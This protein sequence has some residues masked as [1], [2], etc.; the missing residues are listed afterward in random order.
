M[1]RAR[2]RLIRT[3]V[4]A[5]VLAAANAAG[6]GADVVPAVDCFV[7]NGS[8]PSVNK[9]YFGYANDGAQT[10]IAFGDQNQIVPGIGFQGQ[11]TGFNTGTYQRTF[12]ATWNAAAF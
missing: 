3:T 12:A 10:P 1:P 9:V 11:P 5:L 2:R 4:A 8:G 6:A 7:A